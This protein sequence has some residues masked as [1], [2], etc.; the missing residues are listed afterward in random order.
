L[1]VQDL[2]DI[3]S[4]VIKERLMNNIDR[5]LSRVHKL[6]KTG[7]SKW[8]ACCPAHDDKTPSLAIKL[9]D[10]RILIHCFTGCDVSSI[11]SA[12]GLEL[13]D[14]MPESK[15]YSRPDNKR[16]KF[17]KYELFERLVEESAILIV[18]IRQ[19]FKGTQ[20]NDD[21]MERVVKAEGIIDDIIQET[22]R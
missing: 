14:L 9:A 8:L 16:P 13:S 3:T 4:K 12:L 17:N 10:D 11:I 18:A 21:D 6:K 5:L 19:I 1:V 22:R 7:D 20:L 15:R 2:P